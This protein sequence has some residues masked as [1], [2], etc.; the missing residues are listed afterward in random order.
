M[1]STNTMPQPSTGL[2]E[3]TVRVKDG[4]LDNFLSFRLSWVAYARML[5]ALLWRL[6][7]FYGAVGL[8]G[9]HWGANWPGH[10]ALTGVIVWTIYDVL[11]L[12]SMLLY[13][14]V[15]GVW[16]FQ[17]VLPWNKGIWGVKWRDI[18]EATYEPGPLS[19]LLR[20][21]DVRIGHRFTNSTE[22]HLRNLRYGHLAVAHINQILAKN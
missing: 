13:T 18:S 5:Y 15:E 22:L 2:T 21:Y 3:G 20:S 10:A 9:R 8:L 7:L 1:M 16:L 19:W 17:G 14:D 6:F 4:K 11:Y 12:R